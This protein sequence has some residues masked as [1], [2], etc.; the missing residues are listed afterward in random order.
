MPM[1]FNGV[2]NKSD[3]FVYSK[4]MCRVRHGFV[5][6]ISLAVLLVSYDFQTT[7]LRTT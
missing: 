6:I 5:F 7:G 1:H 4:I 2:V 3:V